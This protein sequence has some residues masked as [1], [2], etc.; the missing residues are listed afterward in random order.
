MSRSRIDNK[1]M[2]L[3]GQAL[4]ESDFTAVGDGAPAGAD[5][6]EEIRKICRGMMD[7]LTEEEQAALGSGISLGEGTRQRVE[8]LGAVY[9]FGL[10]PDADVGEND[11]IALRLYEREIDGVVAARAGHCLDLRLSDDLGPVITG[12]ATLIVDAPWLSRRLRARIAEAFEMGLRTPRLF[13]LRNA[14]RA[15][16]LGRIDR[17]TGG[18]L[19]VYENS[20]LPLNEQQAAAVEAALRC[21][22]SVIASPGG[23]GKTHTLA[24]LV[25][26]CYRAGLRVL[27]TAP[28]NVAVDVATTQLCGRLASEPGFRRGD[29]LR[30]GSGAG[31]ALRLTWGPHVVLD[32]VVQRLRP[33]LQVKRLRLEQRVEDLARA[34]TVARRAADVLPSAEAERLG[35]QLSKARA[36]LR[37]HRNYVRDY[38]RRLVSGAR[39]VTTTL[40][41]VFLDPYLHSFDVVIIDEASMAH[42]PAVFLAAGLARRHVVIAGD[43]FQLGLPVKSKDSH[44]EW[45][46]V[47]VF[48]RLNVDNS[49]RGPT[50]PPH[51]T[52]L[53]EQRRSAVGICDLLGGVWY[54]PTLHTAKAVVERE[55]NR[56]NVIFG[57]SSLCFIDTAGLHPHAFQPR[58]RTYANTEHAQLILD[59]LSYI[60]SAGELP[61]SGSQ[62]GQVLVLSHYRGQVAH[63]RQLMGDRYQGRGVSV[64]TIHTAQGSEA[65][66]CI[67]DLTLTGSATGCI[68]TAVQATD[69]GS[70]LLAVACSRARSR[71]IL[72]GD[73]RWVERSA[74]HQSVLGRVYSHLLD[75][76]AYRIPLHEV[77]PRAA[78]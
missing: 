21:P 43:P 6:L 76:N 70:R 13:N 48:R 61:A 55:R 72:L 40:A 2:Q 60:D 27:V 66:T 50:V 49:L 45:L 26:A 69:E 31:G 75:G 29:M 37:E 44:R 77:R 22:V 24:A 33:Q 62:A 52:Q 68:A 58:G 17:A 9:R 41:S 11:A 34:L 47:D 4:D 18:L 78:A 46:D 42:V 36:D 38:T 28:S 74:T 15:I 5:S 3:V 35:R 7:A 53:T 65:T 57:G 16:G 10:P 20:D 59:L 71:L 39:I 51:I 54:G 19:P 25:E 30:I 32:E 63:I 67:L 12:G 1:K 8:S 64:R 73:M 14:L 23:T 56:R